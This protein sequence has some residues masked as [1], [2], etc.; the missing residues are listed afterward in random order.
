MSKHKAIHNNTYKDP[1]NGQEKLA[2]AQQAPKSGE[3]TINQNHNT[4]KE[5]LGPNTKR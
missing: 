2:N 5:P 4:K 1:S 3:L